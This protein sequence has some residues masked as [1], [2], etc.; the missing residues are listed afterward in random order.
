MLLLLAGWDATTL[1]SQ[2]DCRDAS[3]IFPSST[4]T[5]KLAWHPR[6]HGI[7]GDT[8]VGQPLSPK[9]TGDREGR[10]RSQLQDAG[11]SRTGI[12]VT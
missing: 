9:G 3:T 1:P 6:H 11:H 7:Y 5:R 4:Q 12:Y 2:T 8:G 10:T